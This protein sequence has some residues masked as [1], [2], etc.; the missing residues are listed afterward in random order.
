MDRSIWVLLNGE[1]YNYPEWRQELVARRHIFS[2]TADTG[3]AAHLYQ[4]LVEA[5]FAA[6]GACSQ[7]PSGTNAVETYSPF[8]A[9]LLSRRASHSWRPKL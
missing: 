9:P 2:T 8:S 1:I 5:C 7:S 6:S 4:D 3:S